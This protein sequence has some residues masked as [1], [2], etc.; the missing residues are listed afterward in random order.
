[1][2]TIFQHHTFEL[3][4]MDDD[5]AL[6]RVAGTLRKKGHTIR[7]LRY[8][9]AAGQCRMRVEVAPNAEKADRIVPDLTKLHCV[10][11]VRDAL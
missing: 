8:E 9:R 2:S 11:A 1:M 4:V 5:G 7:S 3:D 10:L 6:E